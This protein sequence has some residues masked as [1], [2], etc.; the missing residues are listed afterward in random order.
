MAS[1]HPGQGWESPG[2]RGWSPSR[3]FFSCIC[4]ALNI[5]ESKTLQRF[6]PKI[7]VAD[8]K[9]CK[10]FPCDF[11]FFD[12]CFFFPCYPKVRTWRGHSTFLLKQKVFC[13]FPRSFPEYFEA[14]YGLRELSMIFWKNQKSQV[15]AAKHKI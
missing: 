12:F 9:V 5:M 1:L 13:V 10:S 14:V 4:L 7:S 11:L 6:S 8:L 2:A 15:A 3:D